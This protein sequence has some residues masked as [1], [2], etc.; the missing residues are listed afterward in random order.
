MTQEE[1]HPD[2]WWSDMPEAEEVGGY[3]TGLGNSGNSSKRIG[4]T[5]PSWVGY[6]W[7]RT[8]SADYGFGTGSWVGSGLRRAHGHTFGEMSFRLDL[9]P[10]ES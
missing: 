10:Q 7:P 9:F 4:F 5:M 2:A 8:K 3:P 1:A 6:S